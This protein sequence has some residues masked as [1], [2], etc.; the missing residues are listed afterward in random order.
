ML[1][2]AEPHLPADSAAP[3]GGGRGGGGAVPLVAHLRLLLVLLLPLPPAARH[4]A[5]RRL[6]HLPL[7]HRGEPRAGQ[8]A[9]SRG[10]TTVMTATQGPVLRKDKK[11]CSHL[12]G[13]PRKMTFLKFRESCQSDAVVFCI[14]C[15]K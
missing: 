10:V 9:V 6:L 4:G 5:V 1:F 12:C 15:D 3:G 13:D 11:F 2:A 7:R 14:H 8:L